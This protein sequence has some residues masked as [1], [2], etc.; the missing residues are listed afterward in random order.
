MSNINTVFTDTY[1]RFEAL[2]KTKGY[3]S[4]KAYEEF[5]NE[6]SKQ[7]SSKLKLCRTI[8]TFLTYTS[9]TFIEPTE[10]MVD[11][12]CE[13]IAILDESQ[14]SVKNK[15]IPVKESI[16]DEDLITSAINYMFLR[17]VSS[18]PVFD[19]K[20]YAIGI[21]TFK[22]VAALV[23][24]GKYSKAKTVSSI[25]Q[26]VRFAFC[27]EEVPMNQINNYKQDKT[28]VCLIVSSE[29]KVTGWIEI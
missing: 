6:K 20:G 26:K 15:M 2:V 10:Q 19:S 12:L 18:A 13:Q 21:I 25:V 16:K 1:K 27:P 14:I 17:D 28:S 9:Q 5:I 7:K 24:S 23:A 22:D 29:N 4:A 3:S 11:F 8:Y